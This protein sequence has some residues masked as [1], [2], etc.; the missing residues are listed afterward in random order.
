MKTSKVPPKGK[1]VPFAAGGRQ[2]MLGKGDRT[3][4]KFPAARQVPGQTSQHAGKAAPKRTGAKL[5]SAAVDQA[6][7]MGGS[8]GVSQPRRPAA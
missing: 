6:G 3:V 8:P 1:A 2:K 5:P 4:T 7:T